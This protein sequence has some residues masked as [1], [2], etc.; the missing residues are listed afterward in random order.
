MACVAGMVTNLWLRI[1]VEMIQ[2]RSPTL[3][4]NSCS[5]N[6]NL[7]PNSEKTLYTDRNHAA[8]QI[9]HAARGCSLTN[10][11]ARHNLPRGA[12]SPD[13]FRIP[14]FHNYAARQL[15]HALS[16]V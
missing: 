16:V 12:W 5:R 7:F 1:E 3:N 6:S 10:Y 13:K 4:V 14:F 8:R 11:A 2:S 9:H 15:P